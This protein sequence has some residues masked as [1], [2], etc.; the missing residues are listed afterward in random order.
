[1]FP[2][3]T[4]HQMF[5]F[6]SGLSCPFNY[7]NC[8]TESIYHYRKGFLVYLWSS[9][10][11]ST[12]R[13]LSCWAWA[14]LRW[15]WDCSSERSCSPVRVVVV[16]RSMRSSHSCRTCVSLWAADS[17]SSF[18]RALDIQRHTWSGVCVKQ[19][20]T[21]IEVQCRD[22]CIMYAKHVHRSCMFARQSGCVWSNYLCAFS[23]SSIS[24]LCRCWTFSSNIWLWS[25]SSCR[26]FTWAITQRRFRLHRC[27]EGR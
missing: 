3:L 10:S 6:D 12:S 2:E 15:Y 1:M 19:T 8:W 11:L 14:S 13:S 17:S 21:L 16:R 7:F 26:V 23:M 20:D 25:R 24:C 9:L 22:L 5:F 18:T 27:M 4:T